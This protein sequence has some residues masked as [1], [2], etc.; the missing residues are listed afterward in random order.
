MPTVNRRM[1][2]MLADVAKAGAPSGAEVGVAAAAAGVAA[3]GLLFT[4]P[5]LVVSQ[6]AKL[7]EVHNEY[8]IHDQHG[9]Q[10]GAVREVGLNTVKKLARAF[11]RI[12]TYFDHTYQVVDMTGAPGPGPLPSGGAVPG[13]DHGA[14]RGGP[15]AGD[16]RPGE[17]GGQD[18]VPAE[19]RTA[20]GRSGR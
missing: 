17:H 18:P 19:G 14:G 6:R 9:K 1:K 4:E 15:G 5:V 7:V 3:G 8:A 12:D 13:R 20:T 10:I 2:R 16:D 11:T